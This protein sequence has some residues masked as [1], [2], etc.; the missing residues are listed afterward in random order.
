MISKPKKRM[1]SYLMENRE[2]ARRLILKTR[3]DT[4]EEM[5]KEAGLSHGMRTVDF[6][7]GTHVVPD[8]LT[9]ITGVPATGIDYSEFRCSEARKNSKTN[10]D[11]LCSHV[12]STCLSD[13]QFDFS[14]SRFLFEYLPDPL[15]ALSEMRRVTKQG[16]IVAVADL[17]SQ[18]MNIH[19]LSQNNQRIHAEAIRS[20]SNYLDINVGRRLPYFFS[21]T[22][23]TEIGVRVV[24][25]Q[26]FCGELTDAEVVNWKTKF[27][28]VKEIVVSN[29]TISEPEWNRF[30][31]DIINGLVDGSI[32]YYSILVMVS[33]RV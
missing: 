13:G 10:A 25:H 31:H 22:D 12:E 26:V 23:F 1:S 5:L 30:S 2:E 11:F 33:A 32:F 14:W 29:S 19:P 17:D 18:L 24:P 7:C 21:R 3:I 28:T 20:I 9:T 8:L 16:G 27:E 15:I 6:G 4:T